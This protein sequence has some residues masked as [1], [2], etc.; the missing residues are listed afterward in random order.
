VPTTFLPESEGALQGVLRQSLAAQKLARERPGQALQA[1]ALVHEAYIRLV[2]GSDPGWDNRGH[3]FSA[4]AEAM[5]RILVERARRKM[6]SWWRRALF[7]ATSSS[8]SRRK[9]A[10]NEQTIRRTGIFCSPEG[11]ELA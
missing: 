11:S 2:G 1:T 5:R 6:E 8:L 4:A 9:A 7:S 3:F 10:T